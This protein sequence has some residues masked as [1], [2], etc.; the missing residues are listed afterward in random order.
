MQ[1]KGVPKTLG[2]ETFEYL[3]N[4]KMLKLPG[5][6]KRI[7][8]E[9]GLSREQLTSRK[10]QKLFKI[11]EVAIKEIS[12]LTRLAQLL[13]EDQLRQVFNVDKLYPLFKAIFSIKDGLSL[14]EELLDKKRERLLPFCNQVI[15]LID[16]PSFSLKLAGKDL[17]LVAASG[18]SPLPGVMATYYRS[19]ISEERRRTKAAKLSRKESPAHV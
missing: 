1:R 13:P 11:R 10:R 9:E 7:V 2:E 18:G 12:D 14:D 5:R 6:P 16:E 3:K 8:A 17:R 15:A 4:V 19:M